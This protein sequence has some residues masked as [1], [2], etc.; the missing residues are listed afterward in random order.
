MSHHSG[1][2]HSP[3][4]FGG[5]T[6]DPPDVHQL[7]EAYAPDKSPLSLVHKVERLPSGDKRV[8]IEFHN[9]DSFPRS[10]VVAELSPQAFLKAE[11]RIQRHWQEVKDELDAIG[12]RAQAYANM[13]WKCPTASRGYYLHSKAMESYREALESRCGEV[14]DYLEGLSDTLPDPLLSLADNLQAFRSYYYQ[15]HVNSASS[16]VR[17]DVE[18]AVL[19]VRKM[20]DTCERKFL[21]N[22][23]STTPSD[24]AEVEYDYLGTENTV[25]QRS[26]SAVDLV[27]AFRSALDATD[28]FWCAMAKRVVADNKS[29]KTR[30]CEGFI[31][32]SAQN[33]GAMV[34]ACRKAYDALLGELGD[35]DENVKVLD[36]LKSS[37]EGNGYNAG[38]FLRLAR[39]LEIMGD[40]ERLEN[41]IRKGLAA[42][43]A[44]Y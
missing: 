35:G 22:S 33:I 28:D 21:K 14:R 10:V 9:S 31:Q 7:R 40:P 32:G 6:P 26:E 30:E 4:R 27:R 25:A 16:G 29:L 34:D 18:T 13:K 17:D 2:D 42:G 1:S 43:P 24:Q 8:S 23:Q 3:K 11:E 39:M 37:M 15:P 5:H 19:D 41:T 20:L 12:H 44:R 36:A 38:I